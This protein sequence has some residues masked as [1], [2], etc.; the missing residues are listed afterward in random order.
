MRWFPRRRRTSPAPIEVNPPGEAERL[1]RRLDFSVV[2]RLDG[3]RQGDHRNL[4]YGAGLDLAELREYRPGDDVRALDWNVTARM[5]QP[6]VRRY[7]EDREITAWLVLDLT[8]SLDFGS[9]TL[10]KRDLLI[11]IAGTLARLLTSRGDR[12]GAL[13]YTGSEVRSGIEWSPDDAAPYRP[14]V[15]LRRHEW[16]G[17]R[18]LD[19][20]ARRPANLVTAGQG[21]RHVLH[22]L[23]RVIDAT[24]AVQAAHPA[25]PSARHTGTYLETLLQQAFGTAQQRSL[26]VVL[27][28]FLDDEAGG[29]PL[30]QLGA[31]GDHE[32]WYA[33]E[34]TSRQLQG[35]GPVAW[36]RA[37]APLARRHEVVGV[38]VR[39][40]REV[41]LPDAGVVTFEDVETGEQL[42]VDTS[43][44][45]LRTAYMALAQRR[46]AAMQRAFARAG[47]ALWEVSTGEPLVPALVQ[48]LDRRRRTAEGARRLAAQPA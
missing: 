23:Q 32:V 13:L 41:S 22:L 25:A 20:R 19:E 26:V 15:R 38:W 33:H 24:R 10:S 43:Q 1:L 47:A 21:R 37:L 9:G 28:D 30:D 12:V 17:Q 35:R 36:T 34:D 45:T 42:V 39:D 16:W 5:A 31:D 40:E 11:D 27:S 14:G 2:R 6:Y 8:A 7:H 3:L 46:A 48:F 29:R 44:S 18:R 4:A